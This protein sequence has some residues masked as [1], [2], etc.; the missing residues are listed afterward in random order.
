MGGDEF[1]GIGYI[2][3]QPGSSNIPVIARFKAA[4]ASTENDGSIP[5]GSTLTSATWAWIGPN[6]TTAGASSN[7][8]VSSRVSTN[9]AYAYLTWSSNLRNGLHKLTCTAIFSLAGTTA[10]MQLER[11]LDRIYVGDN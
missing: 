8:I 7:M 6:Q 10:T 5:Y 3:L 1:K 11:D 9:M 4:T 2:D